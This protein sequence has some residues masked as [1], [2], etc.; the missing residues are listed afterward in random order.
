MR[1]KLS[2]GL[3][4]NRKN[5]QSLLL[6]HMSCLGDIYIIQEE[7]IILTLGFIS[8]FVDNIVLCHF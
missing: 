8:D 1:R 2:K 7:A 4:Y 6:G 5:K 3:T